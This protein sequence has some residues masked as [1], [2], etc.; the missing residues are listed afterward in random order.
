MRILDNRD[1][2]LAVGLPLNN[3]LSLSQ[4]NWSRACAY[5][6]RAEGSLIRLFDSKKQN[7]RARVP[8]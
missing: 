4:D 6:R 8:T 2:A 3:K 1:K 5:P 7:P